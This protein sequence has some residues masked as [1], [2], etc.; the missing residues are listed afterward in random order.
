MTLQPYAPVLVM[1]ALAVYGPRLAALFE[2]APECALFLPQGDICTPAG[3]LPL[4]AQDM[5]QRASI[6]A[7]ADVTHLLCGGICG[8]HRRQLS[9]AGIIVVP[10]LCGGV[11]DIIRAWMHDNLGPHIM[12]GC[13]R[14]QQP[15]CRARQGQT[16]QTVK[17]STT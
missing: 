13:P 17:R 6:L 12:P 3:M 10:W 15:R 7:G 4:P 14:I 1:I 9:Q 2:S 16:K 8:C 11:Q 5:L